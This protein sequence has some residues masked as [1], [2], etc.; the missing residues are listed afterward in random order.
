MLKS[1][2]RIHYTLG[3]RAAFLPM[4]EKYPDP[5]ALCR[6]L[7][8]RA[9]ARGLLGRNSPDRF[10]EFDAAMAQATERLC[11]ENGWRIVPYPSDCYP[12]LLR[13]IKD[14]PAVL[15]VRGDP[16]ILKNP[17]T[18]AAVGT[19][20]ASRRAADASVL[21]GEALA[22]AGVTVI[23]GGANGVDSAAALGAS[24]V[25]GAGCVTVLGRGF[26]PAPD[27]GPPEGNAVFVTELFPG[28]SGR[29]FNFPRRNRVISGI[30]AGTVVM[31]A[32]GKSGSLITADYAVR[33]GRP[34]FVP[35]AA[36]LPS[37]GC[38]A[39][40]AKGAKEIACP[41]DC[42]EALFPDFH[43]DAPGSL[44][45]RWAEAPRGR[46]EQSFYGAGAREYVPP[47]QEKPPDPPPPEPVRREEVSPP[48]KAEIPPERRER[49]PQTRPLP[50]GLSPEA[51]AVAA[52]LT[53][54]PRY[55]D[56][57]ID[58]LGIPAPQVQIAVTELELEDAVTVGPGGRISL[59]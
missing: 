54:G 6:A 9:E 2:L 33:Q 4:Y 32:G 59:R 28:L 58:R 19:R 3:G 43:P 18:V 12:A 45:V 53:E 47:E 17:R 51:R 29:A 52:A 1:W 55:V 25:V 8:T 14:P 46:Y 27:A 41:R 34:V 10:F 36:S 38:A 20:T 16:E 23:S 5:Q 49:K 57:L 15:F 24:G 39:L 40:A 13:R 26:D 30:S 7:E 42:V 56:E 50:E 44:S 11:R 48:I 37:P 22:A 21:L 31:E 35:D